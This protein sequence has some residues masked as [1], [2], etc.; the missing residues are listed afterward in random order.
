[1]APTQQE[2]DINPQLN[3]KDPKRQS[4]PTARKKGKDPI[5][6]SQQS[7]KRKKS[8]QAASTSKKSKA[9]IAAERGKRGN[10]TKTRKKKGEQL[11]RKSVKSDSDSSKSDEGSGPEVIDGMSESSDSGEEIEVSDEAE[12]AEKMK[13]WIAPVYDFYDSIPDIKYINGRKCQVFTCSR[14]SCRKEIRRYQDTSDANATK[15]LR[16]HVQA[17][18]TV[19]V[20]QQGAA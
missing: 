2:P 18:V 12:L 5:D 19:L 16:D 1:M 14:T 15:S 6:N 10:V 17:C 9:L 3:P 20:Y 7:R 13:S 4:I 8:K 11:G